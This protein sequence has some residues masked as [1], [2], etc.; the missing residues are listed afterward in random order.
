MNIKR[1]IACIVA[2][3]MGAGIAAAEWTSPHPLQWERKA[4]AALIPFPQKVEWGKEKL[5]IPGR[6]QWK[7]VYGFAKPEKGKDKRVQTAWEGLMNDLPAGKKKSEAPVTCTLKQADGQDIHGEGYRLTVGSDGVTIEAAETAGFFNGLQTLRQLVAG[8]KNLRYCQIVD[9]PAFAV[10]GFHEDCGRNF[11][12]IES[13]KRQL[14]IASRLKVNYFHWHLTDNPGWHV[15]CKAYPQLN[16][17]RHRTRDLHDT[18]SYDQIRELIAFARDRNITIIPELDMPG[19]SQYFVKAFGFAMHTEEGMKVLEDLI[20]EFCKEIPAE[21]CPI[22]HIGADEIK[23]PNAKEFVSRMS[24][25]LLSLGRTPMQWGGPRDLPVGEH[26]ISQRWGEGGEMVDRSLKPETIQCRTIDSSMGYTNLFDPAMLV[27]RWFF[28]RPCGV[29]KGDEQKMGVLICNWPDMRVDDKSSIPLHSAQWPGLCAMAERA[30]I[31][32]DGDGDGLASDMPAPDTE[33]AQA[34]ML[35]EKRMAALR[36]TIFKEE[37]FPYWSEHARK[38]TIIGPVQEEQRDEVRA[39]VLAGKLDGL[40]TRSAYGAN[41]YFRTKPSTGYLG[42]FPRSKR[43]SCVWAVMEYTSKDGGKEPFMI[44]FDAPARSSRRY[45]GVPEAGEWSQCGTKIW[46]NGREFKNPQR[47]K[48]AG[49]NR[50]ERDTWFAPANED[51]LTDEEVW[52]AHKPTMVPL[53]KGKNT[54][55][56]EQPYTGDFQSWGVSFIPVQK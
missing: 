31:G 4:P 52:W 27:R 40:E 30:W 23:V 18:Y 25:L 24:N 21:D 17:A 45:S 33:A 38:W 7:L 13:L 43:G 3:M 35:F 49:K 22:F 51:P 16:D 28:M 37:H 9:W 8:G 36:K 10:R 55:I 54:I 12:S 44:G 14:D 42:L 19:H 6:E 41:I 34:F 53:K 29:G 39:R 56:I 48:L 15:Q 47:Y 46:V 11:Q 2:G 32:G 5:P 26:S 50:Y 20:R 1:A